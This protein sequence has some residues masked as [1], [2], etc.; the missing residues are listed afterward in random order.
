MLYERNIQKF[1]CKKEKPTKAATEILLQ[2][3]TP[4]YAETLTAKTMEKKKTKMVGSVSSF[5]AEESNAFNTHTIT[6][7]SLSTFFNPCKHK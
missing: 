4:L 1:I 7:F 6:I 5:M 3:E 2:K